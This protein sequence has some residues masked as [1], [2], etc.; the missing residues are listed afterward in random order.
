MGKVKTIG[1]KSYTQDTDGSWY[2]SPVQQEPVTAKVIN[3]VQYHKD[4]DGNWYEGEP[5]SKKKEPSLIPS[6]I[7]L[8]KQF[9]P[10]SDN[11]LSGADQQRKQFVQSEASKEAGYIKTELPK[12]IA[13][14]KQE[15]LSAPKVKDNFNPDE[16]LKQDIEGEGKDAM[17]HAL[18]VSEF[19]H[20][21]GQAPD[22]LIDNASNLKVYFGKRMEDFEKQERE[23]RGELQNVQDL[24]ASNNPNRG[25]IQGTVAQRIDPLRKEEK[26]LPQN[27]ADIY[28][29]INELKDKKAKLSRAVDYF[30][31]L[32][33]HQLH[34]EGTNKELAQEY[35]NLVNDHQLMQLKRLDEKQV[36]TSDEDKLSQEQLGLKVRKAALEEKYA[37]IPMDKRPDEYFAQA[38]NIDDAAKKSI[39]KFPELKQKRIGQLLVQQLGDNAEPLMIAAGSGNKAALKIISE[40]TGLSQKELSAISIGDLPSES[41]SGNIGKGIYDAGTSLLTG[42]HRLLGTAFGEDPDRISYINQKIADSGNQ[43]FGNNPNEHTQESPTI[44]NKEL[45]E[46]RNPRAGK[47]NYNATSIKNFVGSA[48]GNLAGFIGGTKG[49]GALGMGERAALWTN[50]IGSGYEN[51]YQKANEILGKDATEGGK[52]IFALVTGAIQAAAFEFLPK[53]KLGLSSGKATKELADLVKTGSI[54]NV[55]KEVL[56]STIQK[57]F[58]GTVKSGGEAA[59]VM[60]A[61]KGSEVA[62]AIITSMV[63]DKEHSNK[64]Y[65]ELASGLSPQRLGEE[66][67]GLAIPL[68]L[69]EIPHNAKGSRVLKENLFDLGL[70]PDEHKASIGKMVDEGKMSEED[71]AK[72][73][74]VIDVMSNIQKTLP[75]TNPTTGEKLTHNQQVEY[76]YNRVKELAVQAKKEGVKGDA[77]LGSFYD[78]NAK[79]LVDE[80]KSIIEGKHGE[81]LDT[82]EMY[83]RLKDKNTAD[84]TLDAGTKSQG[85]EYYTDQALSAPQS[86]KNQLGG[87]VE[88]VTD[89]IAR[90]SPHDIKEEL[91]DLREQH[92]KA[93]TSENYQKAEELDKHITLLEEGLQKTKEN[94][95]FARVSD[96]NAKALLDK[97][98]NPKPEPVIE[99]PI[100]NE[101]VSKP[102]EEAE[103]PIIESTEPVATEKTEPVEENVTTESGATEPPKEEPVVTEDGG[104][105]KVAVHHAGLTDLAEKLE[106]P[107][108][109]R[110]DYVTPQE[111]AARGRRLMDAGAPIEEIDNKSNDLHD[112]IALGRAYLE[113]KYIELDNIRNQK[114]TNKDEYNAKAL[115]IKDLSDKIKKLGSAAGQAMTSLQGERDINTDNFEVVKRNLEESQKGEA[116]PGQQKKIAQLTDENKKLR[117]Q[118][119]DLETK[120]IKATEDA[121]N[122]KS[123]TKSTTNKAKDLASTIRK[124]KIHKPGS[125]SAATPASI[126]WDGAVELVAKSIE[127]GGQLADAISSAIKYIQASKW[128]QGL[129]AEKQKEAEEDFTKWNNEY[130]RPLEPTLESLWNRFVERTDNNFS[131]QESKA[132]WDYAKKNYLDKK[133]SYPDMIS[134]VSNDTGL[135]WRQVQAAITPKYDK[136]LQNT[137]DEMWKKRSE[138]T[139]SQNVTKRWLADQ[140]KNPFVRAIT[141][142]TGRIRGVAVFGHGGIFVGTHAG[143]NLF[144]PTTWNKI[145]PAF[146]NGYKFAYGS[147]GGYERAMEELKNRP[148]YL[149]AERAGLKNNPDNMNVEEF[150]KSQHFLGKLGTAGERGFNAIKVLRQDLFDYHYNRLSKIEKAD[151][152]TA[153]SIAELVNLGTGATNLKI[154]EVI[155]EIS[156]AGGM[157]AARWGKLTRSPLRATSTAL[158]AIFNPRSASTADRVFAKVWARRVGEQ[159]ATFASILAASAALQKVISPNNPT[160]M[161]DP[162]KPDFLKFKF[163]DFTL[164]P[165]SGM[166]ST[167]KFMYDLGKVPF[168]SKEERNNDSKMVAMGKQGI[169]Y[170]RGKLSPGYATVADFAFAQDY[171][172]NPMP[173]SDEKPTV[174]HHKLT[175]GE[176]LWQKA[177]LP[178][179]EAAT[180]AYKAAHEQGTSPSTFNNIAKGAMMGIL[181]GG[182]GFRVG[183]YNAEEA[184]HSS[185]KKEDY[186]KYPAFKKVKEYWGMELPNTSHTS[187]TITDEENKT[188]K[189]L[190]D[191]PKELQ[192]EYDTKHNFYLNEELDKVLGD[193]IAYV[194]K[195]KDANG[196]TISEV[197]L[198]G[199]TDAEEKN[200]EDLDK[201]EKAQLLRLLQSEATKKTKKEIFRKE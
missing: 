108:S 7:D 164:D 25:D 171:N 91:K 153:K 37:G 94:K 23:L 44:I 157:E 197:S 174:G 132:I 5:V 124:A 190:S 172:K 86:L 64:G 150:Q 32:Y 84:K 178:V 93:T 31:K 45:D 130:S 103:Q 71:A 134:N 58:E 17:Q 168:S 105:G 12:K 2:E 118:T 139:K 128:Y 141:N 184:D 65:E 33:A 154:P 127:A 144:S 173:F 149:L 131:S 160:N 59:K 138:Y 3:G 187:E 42:T 182:T 113:K 72:K 125:F 77:A 162:N 166:R 109:K 146:I 188:K 186:E 40:K 176:Y 151:P 181:S 55:D 115:E 19:R 110:A 158:Q 142:V 18:S 177:P 191:Y 4:N 135:S 56:K 123:D 92:S 63:G 21:Q 10:S 143:M 107:A 175:W 147:H 9:A 136:Y 15:E 67:M 116:T 137:S 111:Y 133:V 87:D 119:Q 167:G 76:A 195:Y 83:D 180:E 38:S 194:K 199:S 122:K 36:P 66:F 148:N 159:I 60:A 16:Y 49:L 48:I 54:E 104:D 29:K 101:P 35:G 43:I 140:I 201:D 121:L 96:E 52:N 90:N 85:V 156:F 95:E 34:P 68:S 169:G 70:Q 112:R 161:T 51:N 114:G 69:A 79:E 106:L 183:E 102:T 26:V 170:L 98:R 117:K 53:E 27:E 74:K 152:E 120:L 13:A 185:I 165:T 73:I 62:N 193:G 200:I 163:G 179:A 126:V 30:A 75:D 50:V 41:M 6:S 80:R 100:A 28:T 8:A 78:R 99:K 11:M 22:E 129:P 57:I 189:K 97:M 81:Y 155:N 88:L 196:N 39:N 14:K 82:I 61:T 24:K 1:D 192:Q 20:K 47:Y 46:I 145:I 89:L 198:K